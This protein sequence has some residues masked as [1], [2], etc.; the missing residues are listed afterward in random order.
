MTVQIQH[1]L[2]DGTKVVLAQKQMTPTEDMTGLMKVLKRKNPLP[3]GAKWLVTND[4]GES[5][6][7]KDEFI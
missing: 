5:F 7:W 6:E 2:Q 4:L 1:Q 3:T